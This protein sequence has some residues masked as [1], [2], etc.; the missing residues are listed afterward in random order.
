VVSKSAWSAGSRVSTPAS[1]A[2]C[3]S[4]EAPPK[5]G[6]T[7]RAETAW[8]PLAAIA[9]PSSVRASASAAVIGGRSKLT[10]P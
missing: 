4:Q 1:T 6:E 8:R 9:A 5:V 10:A 2:A 7:T 3:A